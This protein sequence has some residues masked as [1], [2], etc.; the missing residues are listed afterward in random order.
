MDEGYAA[1]ND[2]RHTVGRAYVADNETFFLGCMV[3]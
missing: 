2:I 3:C 1:H